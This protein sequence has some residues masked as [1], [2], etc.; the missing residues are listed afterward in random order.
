MSLDLSADARIR[1]VDLT[2]YIAYNFAFLADVNLR[3]VV[4]LSVCRL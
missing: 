1:L 3:S 2:F 4:C